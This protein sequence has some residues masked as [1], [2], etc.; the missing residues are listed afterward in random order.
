MEY[1]VTN[2]VKAVTK[3]LD[4]VEDVGIIEIVEKFYE[5]MEGCEDAEKLQASKEVMANMLLK[6][7]RD[8]DPVFERVSRAVYVA[9]RSAVL[10][11]NVA[12]GRNLAE[13]VLRRVGAAVLVDRVIEMA[14][15]LIIVAKVSGGVHGEWYL[16]VVNNV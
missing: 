12:H 14:D 4:S 1:I 9:V 15:V 2:S 11:G 10:G 16:Q 6:S 5:F 3:L 7:L 8:G 13:T